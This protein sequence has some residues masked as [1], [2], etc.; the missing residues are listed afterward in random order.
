LVEPLATPSL[1]QHRY[2]RDAVGRFGLGRSAAIL[3]QGRWLGL[4]GDTVRRAAEQADLLVD[5]SGVAAH[6]DFIAKI[7]V[8]LYVDLDPGFTQLWHVSG[9]DVGLDNHTHYATVGQQLGTPACPIPDLGKAWIHVLPPV[10]LE[11]WPV[12]PAPRGAPLFTTVANWRTYGSIEHNGLVLGDK[13]HSFRE[14][15]GLPKLA[16]VPMAVALTI[17]H[18]DD[19]DRQALANGGWRVL[20]A[21]RVVATPD[22]YQR[23]IRRSSAEIGIA[24]AGY[25]HGRTGWISDRSAAYLATGRPV[26]A[27]DTS[28]EG[29]TPTREGLVMF[30]DLNESIELVERVRRDYQAHALAAREIAAGQLSS[31]V[32]LGQLLH[33]LAD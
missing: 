22:A 17:S 15:V 20:D 32:V 13:V 3:N 2:F 16:A 6:E 12:A 27:Q 23:F 26:I 14:F 21:A 25:I 10:A 29:A 30:R 8:R 31:A 9:V 5:L 1:R 24:K 19:G 28:K 7:P 18:E 33:D 11:Y 4:A